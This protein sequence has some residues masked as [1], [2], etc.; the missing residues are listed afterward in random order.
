MRYGR[1]VTGPIS[2]AVAVLWRRHRVLCADAVA[3]VL[4]GV[5][6]ALHLASRGAAPGGPLSAL[7]GLVSQACAAG[8]AILLVAGLW[9]RPGSGPALLGPIPG[10]DETPEQVTE[11]RVAHVLVWKLVIIRVVAGIVILQ[12]MLWGL[13]VLLPV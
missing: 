5:T 13:S 7:A 4:F 10:G 11:R 1:G 6:G 8:A 2:I 9:R 3:V 12:A